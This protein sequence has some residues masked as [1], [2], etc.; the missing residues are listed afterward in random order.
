MI[1]AD[2]L[3]GTGTQYTECK[4]AEEAEEAQPGQP[5]QPGQPNTS[6]CISISEHFQIGKSGYEMRQ[7]RLF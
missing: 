3:D 4:D 2:A 5:G 1:N 7:L 6:I